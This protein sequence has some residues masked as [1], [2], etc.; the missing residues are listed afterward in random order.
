MKKQI[1]ETKKYKFWGFFSQV[2]N[3]IALV[4]WRPI[5]NH[6]T[7]QADPQ[8]LVKARVLQIEDIQHDLILPL[9]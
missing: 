6:H 1:I 9:F 3:Q 7:L 5:Q 2:F 8:I 4:V